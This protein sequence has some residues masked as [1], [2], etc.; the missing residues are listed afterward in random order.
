[1]YH[2]NSPHLNRPYI[3]LAVASDEHSFSF[4]RSARR[5][6]P[7]NSQ[8]NSSHLEV[9][10]S[11]PPYSTQQVQRSTGHDVVIDPWYAN[12]RRSTTDRHHSEPPFFAHLLL[13]NRASTSCTSESSSLSTIDSEDAVFLSSFR[14]VTD[15]HT[16]YLHGLSTCFRK[17]RPPNEHKNSYIR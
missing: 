8:R 16:A 12:F 9:S 13:S 4:D 10:H 5:Q 11:E 17:V 1:M 2:D 15:I 6:P 3:N 14:T 7:I